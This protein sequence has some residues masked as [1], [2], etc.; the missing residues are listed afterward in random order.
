MVQPCSKNF[1]N[2]IHFELSLIILITK[3][4]TLRVSLQFLSLATKFFQPKFERDSYPLNSALR[5]LFIVS[6]GSCWGNKWRSRFGIRSLLMD[7]VSTFPRTRDH[8]SSWSF[9]RLWK[10]GCQLLERM[11]FAWSCGLCF[12]M[13]HSLDYSSIGFNDFRVVGLS[14]LM[15]FIDL[16]QTL[17]TL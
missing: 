5:F 17:F 14:S 1:N 9:C 7:I 15:W 12:Y 4:I 2:L 6:R 13:Q 11:D 3:I 10:W 8:G 16:F